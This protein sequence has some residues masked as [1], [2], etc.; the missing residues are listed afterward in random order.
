MTTKPANKSYQTFVAKVMEPLASDELFDK[1]YNIVA[2]ETR[3]DAWRKAD[4]LTDYY[5]KLADFLLAKGCFHLLN[6][7]TE[8]VLQ[9]IEQERFQ[10]VTNARAAASQQIATP[11]YDAVSLK[12]KIGL[13]KRCY[14]GINEEDSARAIAADEAFLAAHPVSTRR[15]PHDASREVAEF[16]EIKP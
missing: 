5:D 3:R 14:L 11:A 13:A 6:G 8:E 15:R 16:P 9:V 4:A 7:E 2:R 10:A 1:D 12:K